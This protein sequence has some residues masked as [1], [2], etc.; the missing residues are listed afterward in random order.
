M[1]G[2][3]VITL[4]PSNE[5]ILLISASEDPAGTVGHSDAVSRVGLTRTGHPSHRFSSAITKNHQSELHHL[6]KLIRN[7]SVLDL[8]LFT[9][10]VLFDEVLLVVLDCKST[11]VS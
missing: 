1:I 3:V 8:T 7:Q 2:T 9:C 6:P 11:P 4:V 5:R 10:E